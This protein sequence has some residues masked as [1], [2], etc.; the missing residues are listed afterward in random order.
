MSSTVLL[1]YIA[2]PHFYI[3]YSLVGFNVNCTLPSFIWLHLVGSSI[4]IRHLDQNLNVE[5]SLINM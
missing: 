3:I 2:G 4:I 5:C 1:S